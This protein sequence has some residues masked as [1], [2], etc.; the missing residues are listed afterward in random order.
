MDFYERDWIVYNSLRMWLYA[1]WSAL[2]HWL[3]SLP[4][5]RATVAHISLQDGS[6]QHKWLSAQDRSYTEPLSKGKK[7]TNES[8]NVQL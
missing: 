3:S 6:C 4:E 2:S 7:G 5:Q 8:E 1:H